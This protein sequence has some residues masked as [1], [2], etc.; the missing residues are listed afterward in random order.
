M[1]FA[2]LDDQLSKSFAAELARVD[3][4]LYYMITEY[5]ANHELVLAVRFYRLL[6]MN[7]IIE[8]AKKTEHRKG[9]RCSG[10][11]IEL[12]NCEKVITGMGMLLK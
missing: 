1:L 4:R 7:R 3:Q 9:W 6:N 5:A 2:F 8:D 11:K 10:E 12:A